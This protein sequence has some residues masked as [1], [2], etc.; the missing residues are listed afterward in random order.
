MQSSNL[1]VTV[2]YL[3]TLISCQT[4]ILVWSC[5]YGAWYVY[6]AL[7]HFDCSHPVYFK[8]VVKLFRRSFFQHKPQWPHN[9]I[10][11]NAITCHLTSDLNHLAP[12]IQFDDFI[13]RGYLQIL[14][15]R[16]FKWPRIFGVSLLVS[17]L[18]VQFYAR[19]TGHLRF[20]IDWWWRNK[21]LK[22]NKL[23]ACYF[24]VI[25]CTILDLWKQTHVLPQTT[26]P[27]G[28]LSSS[29]SG[30]WLLIRSLDWS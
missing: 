10:L 30:M 13:I 9:F 29:S 14:S 2:T 6:C 19:Q 28:I 5:V 12:L 20:C 27:W 11:C 21:Y 15:L 1:D 17:L 23:L 24:L 26:L 3:I 22:K 4:G 18:F 7:G 16:K 8:S 25:K